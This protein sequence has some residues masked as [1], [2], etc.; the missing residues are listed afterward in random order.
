MKSQ[1]TSDEGRSPC[2]ALNSSASMLQDIK[3]LTHQG[4]LLLAVSGTR[5]IEYHQMHL[6]YNT[7]NPYASCSGNLRMIILHEDFFKSVQLGTPIPSNRVHI[8][9]PTQLQRGKAFKWN[10]RWWRGRGSSS[11]CSTC[12]ASRS[13]WTIRRTGTFVPSFKVVLSRF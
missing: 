6:C 11:G 10:T 13:D 1:D 8:V 9:R 7:C 5:F 12:S 3:H 4:F 2:L